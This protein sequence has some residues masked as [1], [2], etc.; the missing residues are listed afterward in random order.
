MNLKRFLRVI[1][2]K[3]RRD[4]ELFPPFW[5][6]GIK[7]LEASENWRRVRIRLPLN[8]FNR[9][10]GASM[11]GGS[12]A[13]LADPIAAI[14]CAKIFPE[15]STWTRAMHIDF[16]IVGT[17]DLELRF[18]LDAEIEDQIRKELE[19]KGR[20]TPTFKLGFYLKDGTLCTE[21]TN[22]VAIRPKG[23]KNQNGAYSNK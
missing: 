8:F 21:I 1:G 12:Q 23:Y 3:K 4:I 19:E 6:L 9:N 18:E 2:A 13:T 22:T 7:V 16:R 17:T 15:Y 10:L 14:A 11:F 5:L 20:A